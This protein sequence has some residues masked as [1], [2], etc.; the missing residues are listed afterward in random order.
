MNNQTTDV[1]L[2]GAGAMSTC[3]GTLLNQL[4]PSLKIT[5]IERL[6]HVAMESTDVLNNAGTGH[7]G[8]C[9]LNY[10][11][12]AEDGSI[13]I[14]KAL[15]INAAF[16]TSLQFWATLVEK[17]ILPEPTQFINPVPHQSFVWG[18]DNVEFLRKRYELLTAQH[19]F[20]ALE[21]SADPDVIREWLPLV[22]ENRDPDEKVAATRMPYG[23]D[24]NFGQIAKSMT[25][26]L[27]KQDGFQLC[28]NTHVDDLKKQD[29]GTW[30]VLMHDRKSGSKTTINT[31]FVFL[32]VGGGALPLLQ[33]SDIPEG[34]GYAGFPV[35]GQWL[36]CDKPEIVNKHL[37]KVYGKAAVGAPPMS[38]PHLDTRVLSSDDNDGIPNK[39]LLFGPFAGFTTKFLK[40]G[41]N[42]DLIKATNFDNIKPMTMVGLRNVDL[43][44]YLISESMQSHSERVKSLRNYFPGAQE[45]DWTLASAGQ[46]VQIIKKC[47]EQGG[48]LE[49]GTEVVT[50]ADGSL[51]ALLGASPGASI[52]V[53]TMIEIIENCFKDQY[54]EGGWQSKIKAMIPSYQ[55]SLIDDADL[56]KTVRK[57]TLTVLELG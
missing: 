52:T 36:I 32:G 12:Q 33:K 23:S 4:D 37:A 7:A 48:T 14:S 11:P 22:M 53:K 20:S 44:R 25:D 51:A 3:L 19:Q 47:E 49:F 42:F 6:D 28:L 27:V 30:D 56:L 46:R 31:K 29:N 16:E 5:M 41:S 57:R 1:V 2:I 50:S 21:F 9:E 39:A 10:T 13:D 40:Y 54:I 17:G 18:D 35:S 24:V 8:Y 34:D 55:E 15:E 43:T 26:Y 38:V 45:D